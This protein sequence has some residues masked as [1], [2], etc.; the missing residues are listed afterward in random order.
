MINFTTRLNCQEFQPGVQQNTSR[1]INVESRHFKKAA[2]ALMGWLYTDLGWKPATSSNNKSRNLTWYLETS[3]ELM[4]D[5]EMFMVIEDVYAHSMHVE[6]KKVKTVKREK[7][8]P[9]LWT[10]KKIEFYHLF[11][12]K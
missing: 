4:V 7:E 9:N 8:L 12:W 11:L 1:V 6:K 3:E 10:G 5:L 2:P